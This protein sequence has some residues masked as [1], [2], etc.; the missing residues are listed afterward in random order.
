MNGVTTI[1]LDGV[2]CYL[3][4]AHDGYALIDTGYP[5]TRARLLRGLEAAGCRPH[6]LKLIVLT[7][8]DIDHSGNAAYLRAQTGA[9]IAMHPGDTAMCLKDG[10]SRK[11]DLR[12]PE[13]FPKVLYLW[14]FAVAAKSLVLVLRR[15]RFEPF[16][17]DILIGE[18][19]DLAPLG[20]EAVAYHTPGHSKG[21]ISLLTRDGALFCGDHFGQVWGYV[22][23]SRD[24]QAYPSTHE[25]LRSLP[26]RVVYPGHGAAVAAERAGLSPTPP[27]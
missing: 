14:F 6:N 4:A 25:K 24:D 12:L 22:L 13:H 20:L 8:G 23:E 17:P 19:Q 5:H 27:P 21:S 7:H 11:R 10:V 18:G 3:L 2:N 16:S 15:T 1:A 9:R 26:V